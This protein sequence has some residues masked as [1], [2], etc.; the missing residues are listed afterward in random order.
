[1]IT[2]LKFDHLLIHSLQ[3]GGNLYSTILKDQRK[4]V[5][6]NVVFVFPYISVK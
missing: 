2:E 3:N 1:M 4:A 6:K 5:N